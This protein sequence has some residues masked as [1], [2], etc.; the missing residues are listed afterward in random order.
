MALSADFSSLT[1]ATDCCR[2]DM[3]A[4]SV[5]RGRGRG[6]ADAAATA[7]AELPPVTPVVS[8][9]RTLPSR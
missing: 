9:A 7:A 6:A 3:P 2:F 8:R 4:S 5:R 1:A